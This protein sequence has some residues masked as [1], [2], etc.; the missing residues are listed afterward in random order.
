MLLA[1][2]GDFFRS[3]LGTVECKAGNEIFILLW[4]FCWSSDLKA[5]NYDYV[6]VSC[7]CLAAVLWAFAHRKK[8]NFQDE[9]LKKEQQFPSS[10]RVTHK[11][12]TKADLKIQQSFIMHFQIGQQQLRKKVLRSFFIPC[13]SNKTRQQLCSQAETF[14]EL[15]ANAELAY[16]NTISSNLPAISKTSWRRK[17][18]FRYGKTLKF[19]FSLSRNIWLKNRIQNAFGFI[20]RR[21][22]EN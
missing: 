20:R 15:S 5:I 1:A 10:A 14:T 9:T 18:K 6:F 8:S 16:R 4:R 22:Y 19:Y 21:R 13:L 12:E 2:A 7:M 11:F 3:P 17:K